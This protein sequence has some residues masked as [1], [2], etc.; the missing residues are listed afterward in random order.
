MNHSSTHVLLIAFLLVIAAA[1]G[2]GAAERPD[3]LAPYEGI[4]EG[5]VLVQGDMLVRIDG[6]RAIQSG[7]RYVPW[8]G[9]VVPYE[10]D[11]NVSSDNRNAMR[12]AMDAIEAVCTT[13]F[14]PRAG[15]DD[16]VHIQAHASENN[17]EVGHQ[18]GEQIINIASWGVRFTM[19]HE[20]MHTLGFEHE[21][22]RQDRDTYV[23]IH[24]D[25]IEEDMEHNFTKD[26]DF[27][28]GPYDFGSVMHYGQCAFSTCAD[29]G[30]N[31]G[32]CRTITVKS[33]WATDW[34]DRI[35]QRQGF[36]L[37][38][39]ATL[40]CLYPEPLTVFVDHDP[41]QY[42][43]AAAPAGSFLNPFPTVAQGVSAVWPT[44]IVMVQ[45]GHYVSVGM[46]SST[47]YSKPMHLR[48]PLGGVKLDYFPL[49]MQPGQQ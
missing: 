19:V 26:A 48:A 4:P 24:E 12:L 16:Y 34:Q 43:N 38:D 31:P 39:I 8:P 2:V 40:Q 9:G 22:S 18:G 30:T 20:L 44:G 49:P 46:G 6:G 29:C 32:N 5:Y 7:F 10:F 14:I 36:S 25:R 47:K 23:V 1:A 15:H 21:Q 11:A 41:S 35:G 17:S 13:S 28:Y 33:P 45:P 27:M 42:W 3:P 37:G